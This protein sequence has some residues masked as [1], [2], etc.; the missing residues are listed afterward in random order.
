VNEPHLNLDPE[1]DSSAGAAPPPRNGP[2]VPIIIAGGVAAVM[3]LGGFLF[4]RAGARTNKV[5]LAA[6]PKG[7]TV[8]LARA[9]RWRPTRTYVGSIEPWIEARVGPQFTSAYVQ[10]VLVRPGATVRRGEVLAT[11]DCRNASAES[12]AIA[13]R[14][15]AIETEQ[16]AVAH[17]AARVGGLLDGGYASPNEVEQ[18]TAESQSKQAEL[19]STQARLTRASL[20]VNDCILRSPF[21]GEIALRSVDPGAFVRPG[22]PIV[23]VV[24]RQTVRMSADVP[25]VDFDLVAPGRR[26]R[27][28]LLA[29]GKEVAAQVA[30]RSPAADP[31]T[32]TVH[33]EVD[34]ADPKREIPVG[35][36]AEVTLEVGE[37]VP[38]TEIPLSSASV[39]GSTATLFRIE[40]GQAR[41]TRVGVRGERGASLFVDSSLRPGTLLVT[42]GR[43]LLRDGDTVTARVEE[44]AGPATASQAPAPATGSQ[45]AAPETDQPTAPSTASQPAAPAN[46]PHAV[47]GGIGP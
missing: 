26:V 1:T 15:R 11:L 13:M 19:L 47:A 21:D 34:L 35:T 32:R 3:L 29:T 20:E 37:P 46:P 36:T 30:R 33:F 31:S 44:A 10:T 43:S 25:E 24:D 12:K 2:S 23:S 8:V 28:R 14:A 16:A 39:R 42:E 40:G 9:A 17:E 45:P 22:N 6:S 7:V 38:A 41:K 5:A 18:K 27:M 4:V